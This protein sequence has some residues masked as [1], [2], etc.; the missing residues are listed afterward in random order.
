VFDTSTLVSAALRVRSVPRQALLK[1]IEG[2]TLCA[3]VEA[4]EELESVLHRPKF[5]RYLDEE[6][7]RNFLVLVRGEAVIVAVANA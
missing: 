2:W 4:L 6:M 3:S 1:A 5:N 7:R